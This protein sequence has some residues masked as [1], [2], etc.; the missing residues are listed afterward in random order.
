MVDYFQSPDSLSIEASPQPAPGTALLSSSESYRVHNFIDNFNDQTE[1]YD[2]PVHDDDFLNF[3]QSCGGSYNLNFSQ[4]GSDQTS[5]EASAQVNFRPPASDSQGA[6]NTIPSREDNLD[7]LRPE[8]PIFY[9]ATTS[10]PFDS[11][12]FFVSQ[13]Y[14]SSADLLYPINPD[15]FLA[16]VPLSSDTEKTLSRNHSPRHIFDP[17]QFHPS[18]ATNDSG[19]DLPSGTQ[20]INNNSIITKSSGNLAQ[21]PRQAPEINP[22]PS[23][24]SE[25]QDHSV[26]YLV[27][28]PQTPNLKQQQPALNGGLSFGSDVSFYGNTYN[29]PRGCELE[30]QSNALLGQIT[31]LEREESPSSTN[32]SNQSAKRKTSGLCNEQERSKCKDK[33]PKRR[34]VRT[35]QE[36]SG[37][38]S[39][40]VSKMQ[41]RQ[42]KVYPEK[43]SSPLLCKDTDTETSLHP[44]KQAA[45][46]RNGR[47][48][49]SEEQKRDNHVQSEQKRRDHIKR[50]QQHL[51]NLVPNLHAGNASKGEVLAQAYDRLARLIDDVHVLRQRISYS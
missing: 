14:H 31:C 1:V 40:G 21:I 43:K 13:E 19:H 15:R 11:R 23:F 39:T 38:T 4:P 2:T 22:R 17:C 27:L 29:A 8:P 26:E 35:K 41:S 50:G 5:T 45:G 3:S 34:K 18:T 6:T 49:L 12:E 48:N 25:L 42:R 44:A 37:L 24:S 46:R 51:I 36:S 16:N 28:A 47:E 20:Q 9:G 32:T 7:Y 33:S 30:K 10:L